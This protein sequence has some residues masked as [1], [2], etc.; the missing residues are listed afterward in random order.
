MIDAAGVLEQRAK[1]AKAQALVR[2]WKYRQR[3]AAGGVW[4]ELRRLLAN[5]ERAFALNDDDARKL[6]DRGARLEPVGVRIEPR[7]NIIF[8][9]RQDLQRIMGAKE[10]PVGLGSEFLDARNVALVPFA[11]LSPVHA[12]ENR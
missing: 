12:P 10:I 9:G 3:E 7:K 6:L 8:V 1:A 4:F 2:S 11:S 5:A